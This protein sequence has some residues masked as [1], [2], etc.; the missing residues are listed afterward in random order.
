MNRKF[1]K[2]FGPAIMMLLISGATSMLRAESGAAIFNVKDYGATGVKDEDGQAA[3]QK[4][5]DACA[6]AGGGTVYLPA[7]E[8]TSGTIHLRS[9]IRFYIDAGATL[10][11]TRD[12]SH[13]DAPSLLYGK[14]LENLTIEGRGTI[15]GQAKYEWRENNFDDAYIRENQIL[16][17][18]TGM[19]LM[20]SFPKGEG[21]N[22]FYPRMI[23][24]VR[25]KD[26]RIAGLSILHSPSWNINP[27][28]CERM[29]IDGIYIYSSPHEAVWADGIDPDGCKDL[30]IMNCT[31][32]TG[33]DALVFYSSNSW[34]P[35][36]PCENITVT[37]CRFTSASS[38]VKFCD[39]IMNCVRNVTIDN[40]VITA[41]NRGIAFMNFSG[42]YV[43][44]V[45]ISNMVV[46][47]QRFD[48]FW[49]GNGDPIYFSVRRNPENIENNPNSP[50]VGVIRNVILRNIIAHGQG[51][52]EIHGHRDSWLQNISFENVHFFLSTDPSA[53]YERSTHAMDFRY[54]RNLKLKDVEVIWE[55]P[56][57][58]K[59]Q[60][61]I[62]IQDVSGLRVDGF[63]GKG[64]KAEIPALVLNDVEDA[65]IT[66]SKAEPGTNVFLQVQ[67]KESNG[68]YLVGNEL[69]DSK[70][71]YQTGAD[72]KDGA[73]KADR[74]F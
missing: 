66:N 1:G 28:A 17:Q 11:A 48:W 72:V 15:D 38:A 3:I 41:A 69:H 57:S 53:A 22:P 23:H 42:G 62:H 4:A 55:K 5:V 39:G 70:T 10:Y 61:A 9:H 6:K 49:W 51:A 60:S 64:A 43:A 20:R 50:P 25:C 30:R 74:N 12:G 68:I 44:N 33:D 31:I 45:V 54:A 19:R 67:G 8:Y 21:K 46:N 27:Y 32:V 7:G 24:L 71:P 26:V 47:T 40:C 65:S 34:G 16:A 36:L 13:Y 73:V 58:A 52:C 56:E 29:V 14:D 63:M 35:A 59:W 18:A 2:L 37:N